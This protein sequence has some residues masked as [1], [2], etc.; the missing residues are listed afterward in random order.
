MGP[1][2]QRSVGIPDMPEMPDVPDGINT[3]AIT[4]G[5]STPKKG[6]AKKKR[7]SLGKVSGLISGGLSMMSGEDA[8]GGLG[9]GGRERG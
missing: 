8:G 6:D 7:A 5:L 2:C 9:G 4:K 1:L 3:K